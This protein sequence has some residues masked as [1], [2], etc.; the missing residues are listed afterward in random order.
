MEDLVTVTSC[1]TRVIAEIIK[2]KLATE[3]IKSV[4]LADDAGGMY[5]FPL[6][7]GFSG[8]QIQVRKSDFSRAKKV[9]FQKR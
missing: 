2:G 6:Q 7:S 3:N 4:I 1:S 9:L 5:P 8:I